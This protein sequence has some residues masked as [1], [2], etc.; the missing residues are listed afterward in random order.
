MRAKRR[1]DTHQVREYIRALNAGRVPRVSDRLRWV[2]RLL[3]AGITRADKRWL[4][5]H[6]SRLQSLKYR[7]PYGRPGRPT[8]REREKHALEQ[9]ILDLK[10][11]VDE[12]G[13]RG[14]T[15]NQGG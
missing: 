13:E 6:R 3:E 14:F 2:D 9:S 7:V 11:L 5:A 12:A 10:N 1:A 8:N 15:D 4:Y